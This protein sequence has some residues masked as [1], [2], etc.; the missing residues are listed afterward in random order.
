MAGS[1]SKVRFL[2]FTLAY[3]D[4]PPLSGNGPFGVNMPASMTTIDFFRLLR[5]DNPKSVGICDLVE[6]KVYL[7]RSDFVNKDNPLNLDADISEFV[8]DQS[9]PLYVVLPR[10][11]YNPVS[12]NTR[13]PDPS[14]KASNARKMRWNNIN[15]ALEKIGM[16]KA[17]ASGSDSTPFSAV[18]WNTVGDI[19]E[20]YTRPLALPEKTIRKEDMD[21]LFKCVTN[22][23]KCFG[24]PSVGN[25]AKR[26]YFIAPILVSVCLLLD[27]VLIEVEENI[28]GVRIKTNGKFEFVLRRKGKRICIMEAKTGDMWQGRAQAL[29]GCET[30]ADLEGLDTV[31]CVI[32]DFKSWHFVCSQD[33]VV[34]IEE[35]TLEFDRGIPTRVSLGK[36]AGKLYSLLS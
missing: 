29:L 26:L 24:Y 1:G 28:R 21:V 20:P 32:T 35:T 10:R 3:E 15:S 25:E 8:K 19:F 23:A 22:V 17:V 14:Y 34:W 33:Q 13:A 30:L 4:V 31:Y 6:L 2:W 5:S 16:S 12:K 18:T 9:D 36:I 11:Y 7:T 27:D